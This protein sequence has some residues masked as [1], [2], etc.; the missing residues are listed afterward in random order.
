MSVER[1]PANTKIRI[2]DFRSCAWQKAFAS[3][4]SR[5]YSGTSQALTTAARKAIDDGEVS[6]GKVLWLLSD[7]CSMMLDAKSTNEP[8]RPLMIGAGKR[9]ALPEDFTPDELALFAQVAGEIDNPWL[10]AR[11]A[12][13]VWFAQRLRDPKFALLAIDSYIEVPLDADTWADGEMTAGGAP[14]A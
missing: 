9:S 14:Y 12:D 2:E 13:L 7:A 6:H 8:F 5:G 11:L 3:A 10:R 4:D 1:Y